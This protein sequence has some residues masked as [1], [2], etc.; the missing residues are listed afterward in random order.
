VSTLAEIEAAAVKLPAEQ[1]AELIRF[2]LTQQRRAVVAME[3]RGHSKRGFPISKGT[4]PFGAADVSRI[5]REA[6]TG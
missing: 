4:A 2:L 6:E 5:E 1:Q 3:A